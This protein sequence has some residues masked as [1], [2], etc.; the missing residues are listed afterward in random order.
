MIVMK[1]AINYALNGK[2]KANT[3]TVISILRTVQAIIHI[4]IYIYSQTPIN[5]H[6]REDRYL[7]K[8]RFSYTRNAQASY[9]N[10]ILKTSNQ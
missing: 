8:I 2:R 4:Y 5:K 6:L 7:C 1:L 9:N 10:S 3:T